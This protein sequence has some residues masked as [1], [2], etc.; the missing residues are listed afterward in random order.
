MLPD[1]GN[2]DGI[3]FSYTSTCR[4]AGM[5]VLTSC[6]SDSVVDSPAVSE[7]AFLVKTDLAR[8]LIASRLH[9]SESYGYRM[10]S[11]LI[12]VVDIGTVLG[13]VQEQTHV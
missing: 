10:S 12:G 4:G 9:I 3:I 13:G 5:H 7:L 2:A 1:S 6:I 11:Q 8:H